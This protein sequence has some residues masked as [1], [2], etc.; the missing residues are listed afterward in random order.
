MIWPLMVL[1]PDWFLWAPIPPGPIPAIWMSFATVIPQESP[2][3]AP[4]DT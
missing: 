4:G 1:E 2:N 3:E